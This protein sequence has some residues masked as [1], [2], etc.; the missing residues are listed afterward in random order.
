[1]MVCYIV[2][3]IYLTD[4]NNLFGIQEKEITIYHMAPLSNIHK[5]CVM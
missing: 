3:F 1:M 2:H 5:T 4:I